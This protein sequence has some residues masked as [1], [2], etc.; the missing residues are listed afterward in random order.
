MAKARAIL[1]RRKAVQNIRKITRTMQLISTARFQRAYNRAT[2]FRPYSD[3]IASMVADVAEHAEIDHPL[4]RRVHEPKRIALMIITANRGLC[5]GY[6]SQV[7]G[8]GLRFLKQRRDEG[9]DVE[10]AA[11]GK[12]GLGYLKFTGTSVDRPHLMGD[13]PTYDQV[14]AIAERYRTEFA[15]G[16]VDAVHV[17]YMRFHSTSRQAADVRQLLP[18]TATAERE[19]SATAVPKDYDF[20]PPAEELLAELLPESVNVSLYQCFI[21]A[22]VSEHVARM[23]AMKAATDNAAEMIKHLGRLANRARQAQI[24][25][26][27]TELMAGAEGLK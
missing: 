27:L 20:T 1:K 7:L 10:L 16:R 11:V 22:I 21:D 5:G 15:A 17:A 6:N 23:V 24:T 25:S 3:R 4:L 13:D 26:E 18:V 9:L 14:K 8:A 19:D 2:A 12:K